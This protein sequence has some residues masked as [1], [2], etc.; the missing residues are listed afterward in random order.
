MDIIIKLGLIFCF[1][2]AIILFICR[3]KKTES[4]RAI[5]AI[6]ISALALTGSMAAAFKEQIFSFKLSV[7]SNTVIFAVPDN[8]NELKSIPLVLPVNF[9]NN[10]YGSG[11]IDEVKLFIEKDEVKMEYWSMIEVDLTKYVQGIGNGRIT[12]ENILG[13]GISSVILNS[14]DVA[15][16]SIVFYRN[17]DE[18]RDTNKEWTQ[19]K[20]YFN[21]W[22][23]LSG[24]KDGRVYNKF[25]LKVPNEML[26]HILSRKSFTVSGV[27]K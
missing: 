12:T 8:K 26:E 13:Q 22:V 19:G 24:E 5:I 21:I 25:S 27:N 17:L 15:T 11:I 10:G 4:D 7:S 9:I 16:R 18:M 3:L 23:K 14:R 1:I 6:V 20:Y 2:A